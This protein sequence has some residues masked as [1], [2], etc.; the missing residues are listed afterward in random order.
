MDRPG[1]EMKNEKT[2]SGIAE[3]LLWFASGLVVGTGLGLLLAPKPGEE[4]RR[5]IADFAADGRHSLAD[6]GRKLVRRGREI[7]EQGRDL[8][9]EAA[10]LFDRGRELVD[11]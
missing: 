5:Q 1:E 8:A 6:Q 3:G 9:D 4:T 11:N 7:F 2:S 10:A